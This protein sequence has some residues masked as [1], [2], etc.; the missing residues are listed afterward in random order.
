MSEEK[1]LQFDI[2]ILIA[3]L[4]KGKRRVFKLATYFLL[5][6]ILLAL[7]T[8]N[9][10]TASTVFIPQSNKEGGAGGSL[11]GLAAL[12]GVNLS[13]NS[14]GNEI[15]PE[16]YDRIVSS[17]EYKSA[18]AQTLIEPIGFEGPI[19]YSQYYNDY[20]SPSLLDQIKKYTLGLPSVIVDLISKNED[21]DLAYKNTSIRQ[22]S[23]QEFIHFTRLSE[24]LNLQFNKK[25]GLVTLNFNM[26]DPLLAA[27]M[28]ESAAN[29]LQNEVK[30]FKLQSTSEQ[31]NFISAR[32]LMK[33]N[34]FEE[35]QK[36]LAL[37][38]DGNQ[39]ISSAIARNELDRLES[40][41]DFSFNVYLE[42]AKQLEQTKLQASKDIP[43]FTIIQPVIVPVG[44]SGP[45]RALIALTYTFLGLVL[46]VLNV[47]LT[48]LMPYFKNNLQSV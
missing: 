2:A 11:G 8:P 47:L 3:L 32:F 44:K 34:E 17:T 45:N 36:K 20:F 27:Q 1:S 33:K 6:G 39:N 37:F 35:D 19:S 38:R 21:L 26:H 41:R 42:L 24:Q 40:Q 10:F 7:L 31:L 48:G 23:T 15:S 22:L 18:L 9:V 43:I 28:V 5:L 14:G 12:A 29:L 4:W 46:G 16:I 25:E 13:S 30:R